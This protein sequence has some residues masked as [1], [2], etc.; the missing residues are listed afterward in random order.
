[1]SYIHFQRNKPAARNQEHE[2]RELTRVIR[3]CTERCVYCGVTMNNIVCHPHQITEDHVVP[4]CRG[5]KAKVKCCR[6]CNQSKHNLSL[7]E[8]RILLS[9]RQRHV[10]VFYY[11]RVALRL[12]TWRVLAFLASC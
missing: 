7:D 12:F 11:E 10:H 5:G 2:W 8:W 4:Q 3:E 9:I 6:T 1:M